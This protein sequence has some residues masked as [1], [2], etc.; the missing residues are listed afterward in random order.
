MSFVG[1]AL[2]N[3]L[4]KLIHRL[5]DCELNDV[6]SYINSKQIKI[7][8]CKIVQWYKDNNGVSKYVKI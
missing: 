1:Y 6:I 8:E 7:S 5:E 3:N 2:F 4:N